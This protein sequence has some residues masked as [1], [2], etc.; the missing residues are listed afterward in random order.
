MG[1]PGVWATAI[2]KGSQDE[3]R[4]HLMEWTSALGLLC[5]RLVPWRRALTLG[6]CFFLRG[7][8]CAMA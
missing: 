4:A 6:H 3:Y 1:C 7:P 8:L 2:S 5:A